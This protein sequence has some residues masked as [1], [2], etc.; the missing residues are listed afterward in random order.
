MREGA[1]QHKSY[2]RKLVEAGIAGI[3]D[4]DTRLP[5]CDARM[6]V[7]ESLC[8]ALGAVMAVA[9]AGWVASQVV[10]KGEGRTGKIAACSALGLCAALAWQSRRAG[11][12]LIRNAS[13]EMAK[14][15]DE[16]WLEGHP[17]DYA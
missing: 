5:Q 1:V 11:L 7:S 9:A 14:V 6:C 16:H 17:I 12:T 3:R 2:G 15:R 4:G 10:R 8:G 13:R